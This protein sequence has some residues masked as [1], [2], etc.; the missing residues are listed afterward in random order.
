[1]RLTT[2]HY[3]AG[4]LVLLHLAT[5][6]KPVQA[7]PRVSMQG[8]TTPHVNVQPRPQPTEKLKDAGD[9]NAKDLIG[10]SAAFK[11]INSDIYSS[12]NSWTNLS[13]N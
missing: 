6:K 8:Y 4:T 1:M 11:Q 10:Y 12:V 5:R 2:F 7:T 9:F 3:V 13:S